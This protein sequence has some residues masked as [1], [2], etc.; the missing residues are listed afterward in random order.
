[1]R[2]ILTLL[3]LTV[4]TAG[5]TQTLS[6]SDLETIEKLEKQKISSYISKNGL[7]I[8]VGDTISFGDPSN[9]LNYL[10]I[11]KFIVRT[12]PPGHNIA[13]N[14]CNI[15]KKSVVKNFEIKKNKLNDKYFA[16]MYT[17]EKKK[18]S[19]GEDYYVINIEDALKS[20]EISF[21]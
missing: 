11:K 9:G 17:G 19:F 10:H 3:L 1:M 15:T 8:N 5:F 18:T 16:I 20:K 4:T 21:K 2:T 14:E 12:G 6:Y 7:T 13:P